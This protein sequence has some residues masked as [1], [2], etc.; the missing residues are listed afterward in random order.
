MYSISLI[1]VLMCTETR[2][3][4]VASVSDVSVNCGGVSGEAHNLPLARTREPI[5]GC[6]FFSSSERSTIYFMEKNVV[7]SSIYIE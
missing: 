1:N 7:S 5:S 3:H 6:I 4:S 2:Y